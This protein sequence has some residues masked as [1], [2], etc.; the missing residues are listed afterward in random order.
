MKQ[1]KPQRGERKHGTYFH[2]PANTHC[3]QHQRSCSDAGRG[4]EATPFRL[5]GRH[6]PRTRRPGHVDQRTD[7]S[8]AY[9]DDISCTSIAL[10]LHAGFESQF[11]WLGSQRISITKRFCVANRL[12]RFRSKPFK[13]GIGTGIHPKS[14]RAPSQA[15]IQ[16]G[17]RGFSE[18]TRDCIR[19]TVFVGIMV[20]VVSPLRGLF[21]CPSFPR[22]TPWA[23]FLRHSVTEAG[24][25]RGARKLFLNRI[26]MK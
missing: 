20:E 5:H 9:S 10:R 22:L 17:V 11:V 1:T 14:R 23:K 24:N 21:F 26:V 2:A 25:S 12:R 6:H 15:H 16:R 13:L 3:F 8:C 7:R 19:R 18:A 4:I